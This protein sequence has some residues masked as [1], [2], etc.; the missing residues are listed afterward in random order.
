MIN[1]K[2][3]LSENCI[4]RVRM[5]KY[6][7]N[8][9][10]QT[11]MMASRIIKMMTQ[12]WESWM[13]LFSFQSIFAP[14]GIFLLQNHT[15]QSIDCQHNFI[16]LR[17][18]L[19]VLR[20][21]KPTRIAMLSAGL[22]VKFLHSILTKDEPC[23]IIFLVRSANVGAWCNGNTWVS[24]TFVEGSSPSAPATWIGPESLDSGPILVWT[25]ILSG[26]LATKQ[27]KKWRLTFARRPSYARSSRI[28]RFRWITP[29]L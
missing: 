24:K 19:F 3:L 21:H 14:P 2:V 26:S 6:G 27:I 22:R 4:E 28:F 25:R 11:S 5:M 15:I 8:Q 29:A 17:Y 7:A 1:N 18:I 12:F 20:E 16:V 23:S 9:K 13:L 10:P